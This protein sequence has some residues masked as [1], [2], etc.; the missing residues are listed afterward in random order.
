[1][2]LKV[3]FL[4]N[5][6]EVNVKFIETKCTFDTQFGE[7]MIMHDADVYTGDYEVTPRVYNQVLQTKDKL[8]ND[9]VTIF[10]IPKAMVLNPKNGY[11]ITIG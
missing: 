11:T 10:Q 4:E 6:S 5:N 8:L 7:I 1:M 3:D 2:K 9:D